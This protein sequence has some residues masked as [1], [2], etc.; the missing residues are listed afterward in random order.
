MDPDPTKR[1]ISRRAALGRLSAGALLSLGLWPGCAGLRNTGGGDFRFAVVNDTHYMTPEC[2]AWLEGVVQDIKRHQGVEFCLLV[3]DLVETGKRDHL[4]AVRDIFATLGKPVYTVIGNHDYLPGND[5]RA[6]DELFP[7]R[8]N[9]WFEHRGWQFVGLDSSQGTAYE[10]TSIQGQTLAWVRDHGGRLRR[11]R[12]TILFTH[13]PLG[14]G[15]RYRPLNA[16]A[17]LEGF[18]PFNVRAVFNGHFH[19]F[20][21]NTWNRAAV[22]TNRCCALK[23]GNHDGTREKGYFIC[24]AVGGQVMRTFVECQTSVA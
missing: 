7:R 2:G 14:D 16:D 4:A 12:P 22:T 17:L 18:L 15:V 9:Y 6:Y 23:R 13:F 8:N 5:R 1:P 19:G 10:K 3:G 20:T 21:E 24:D 11:A